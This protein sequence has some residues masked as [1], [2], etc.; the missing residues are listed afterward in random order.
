MCR[1]ETSD[2]IAAASRCSGSGGGGDG[3]VGGGGSSDGDVGGGCGRVFHGEGL[4]LAVA[5]A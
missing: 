1:S 4:Y 3:Y 2:A 5:G